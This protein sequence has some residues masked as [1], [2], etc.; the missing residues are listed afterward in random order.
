MHADRQPQIAAAE[1]GEPEQ[2]AP[3]NCV[4][5]AEEGG[6]RIG[7]VH[8]AENDTDRE[9]GRERAYLFHQYLEGVTAKD[10]LFA[11][12]GKK[13]GDQVEN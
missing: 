8:Q 5:D 13:D 7:S 3:D 2:H 10:H 6:I 11:G 4:H 1:E 9:H 12:G